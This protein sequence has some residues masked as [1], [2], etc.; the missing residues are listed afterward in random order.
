MESVMTVRSDVW[1]Y[2]CLDVLEKEARKNNPKV[3]KSVGQSLTSVN[4]S[5]PSYWH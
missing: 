4:Q 1:G 5:Q 3:P 2:T